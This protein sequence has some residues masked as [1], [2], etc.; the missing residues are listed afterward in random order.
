[1][2]SHPV[3]MSKVAMVASQVSLGRCCLGCTGF[4]CHLQVEQPETTLTGILA[5]QG[6]SNGFTWH[7]RD[8]VVLCLCHALGSLSKSCWLE[9]LARHR[10]TAI[11]LL[12]RHRPVSTWAAIGF[13]SSWIVEAPSLASVYLLSKSCLLLPNWSLLCW[14]PWHC[15]NWPCCAACQEVSYIFLDVCLGFLFAIHWLT[16]KC[17]SV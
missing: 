14:L 2:C 9:A 16:L 5:C 8:M 7:Q 13:L 1:M 3:C 11:P 12:T 4:A 10:S 15:M 17:G 6:L